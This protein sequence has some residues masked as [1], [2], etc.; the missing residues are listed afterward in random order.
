MISV[1]VCSCAS[2]MIIKNQ[3]GNK[4]YCRAFC[5]CVPLTR[6]SALFP[7]LS[8]PVPS[9]M[10]YIVKKISHKN[11]SSRKLRNN[12]REILLTIG[13]LLLNTA[14]KSSF[15]ETA[16]IATILIAFSSTWSKQTTM[17]RALNANESKIILND[18]FES[19]WDVTRWV[20]D[21]TWYR[22][23]VMN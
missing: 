13:T 17:Q 19:A 18:R 9:A 14:G 1:C 23:R 8:L 12:A 20:R 7:V 6:L 15:H 16:N 5:L 2:A 22:K 11:R 3:I 10:N 4:I 21:E